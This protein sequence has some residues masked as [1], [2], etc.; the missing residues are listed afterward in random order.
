MWILLKILLKFVLKFGISNI[1]ALV[2]IMAWRWPGNKP[3]SEATM[4]SLLTHIC[5]IRPQW[6]NALWPSDTILS[7][8]IKP[9]PEPILLCL[10]RCFVA[11]TWE[12]FHKKV[13]MNLTWNKCLGI[14]LLK[15][16]PHL[17]RHNEFIISH[18]AH[19]KICL[20][21]KPN[22][23]ACANIEAWHDYPWLRSTSCI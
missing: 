5:V 2:Q 8:G 21:C 19:M 18:H 10:Q 23:Y 7:D 14:T 20:L 22:Q 6:V 11:F 17:P 1:P 16:L 15:L 9:L 4:V 3:L 12:Q 13:L